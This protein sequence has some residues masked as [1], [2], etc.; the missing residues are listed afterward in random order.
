MSFNFNNPLYQ[1]DLQG[2]LKMVETDGL[3]GKSFLV[4][5]AT[6]MIGSC[7][8]DTLMMLNGCGAGIKV[9]AVGR[10]LEKVSTRFS[11]CL[12]N[13][14]FTFIQQDVRDP[15]PEDLKVDYIIPLASNTHPLAYSQ[16]PIETIFINVEGARFALDLASRCGAVVIYPS[17]VEIYGNSRDGNAFTETDTGV[18]NLA[19]AR[20]C[21]TE[22]KRLSESMCQSFISECGVD[23]RIIRF[24]RVFG[25]TMLMEDSKAS[26]QFIK[27]AL[28]GE[29]IVLKSKGDQFFSY[30]YV[31][32]AVSAILYVMALGNCGEVYNVAS[33]PFNVHLKDFAIACAKYAS[34]EVVYDI[35]TESERKGY[36]IASKAI[37]DGT[38]IQGLGWNPM[39]SFNESICR[40]ISIIDSNPFRD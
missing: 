23:A 30:T 1:E 7:L 40:T 28:A 15:L 9:Y 13:P 8:I 27:K 34:T 22:S 24:S 18:L 32:D 31:V 16:Y 35:P 39:Y 4:T 21:Y 11:Y 2:I 5:G 17:S 37:M 38:K 12:D 20:S 36:S 26:S 10:N 6:G 29:D 33:E 3:K 14:D 19:T 25:P